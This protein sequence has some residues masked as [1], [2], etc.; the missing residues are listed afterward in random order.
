ME[1]AKRYFL[2]ALVILLGVLAVIAAVSVWIA[3]SHTPR[4][5]AVLHGE[6][7]TPVMSYSENM[8]S[9]SLTSPQGFVYDVSNDTIIY[10][11]GHERVVYPGS[12]TKLLTALYALTLLDP[13][14]TVIPGNELQLVREGSSIAYIKSHHSLTVE[15]LVQAMLIPSG[16]D[17]SYVLAAAA[18]R[19]LSGDEAADGKSA[20]EYFMSGLRKYASDIGLCGTSLTVPDGYDGSVHYTT[21]EDM[22]IVSRL[23]LQNDIIRKYASMP[24][25]SVVYASGHTNE[26]INTNKLLDRDGE[27]YSEYVTGL[28]TGSIGGEYSLI[29]SFSLGDGREYIAGVFGADDKDARFRDALKMIEELR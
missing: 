6:N 14:E 17:A 13:S 10:T 12:T 22:I 18:G 2:T 28:K 8:L 3:S 11:K 24:K 5:E 20:V 25:A 16:N 7:G 27:F 23:A 1:K 21:T 26:W 9:L 29:F 19:K 4:D 15:M